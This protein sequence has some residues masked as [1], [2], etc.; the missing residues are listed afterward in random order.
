MKLMNKKTLNT[1]LL[2]AVSGVLCALLLFGCEGSATGEKKAPSQ[3]Q[4]EI[5]TP[6]EFN[7]DSA[8]SALKKQVEFGPRVPGSNAHMACG[9]WLVAKL[10]SRGAAIQEQKTTLKTFDG[11]SVPVRN[12]VAAFQTENRD[13]VLLCAHWDTRPFA[14]KETDNTMRNKAID[15]AND[16]ASGV[17][18]LLEIARVLQLKAPAVGIDILL[19][20]VEDS[21]AAENSPTKSGEILNPGF[22]TSWCL[23]SQH[24]AKNPHRPG[25]RARFGVLL[26]MVGATD[27][28]FN[29]ERY[30]TEVAPDVV[31]LIWSTASKL[32]YGKYFL[33]QD[34]EGVIDDHVMISR[35]GV[36]CI[37]IIDTRPTPSAMGLGGYVFGPY[38]HTHKD[39][40]DIIDAATLKA[41]G[42]TLLQ[43]LYNLP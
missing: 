26:D 1:A 42:Q 3:T 10:A 37:D 39:N 4:K 5:I 21:G 6:P 20:D 24:W 15:G 14:D 34:V 8:Y 22:V 25:Y 19:L 28:T 9:D 36:R 12:I 18:V 11:K 13:R 32:G 7:A 31:H 29:K 23:G 16:G 35:G 38:H 2:S 40:M 43:V 41:T 17:A 30:S 27:A 33:S